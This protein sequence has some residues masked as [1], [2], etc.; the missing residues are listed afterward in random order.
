MYMN[1]MIPSGKIFTLVL[2]SFVLFSCS[3]HTD[4][5]VRIADDF[6]EAYTA[7]DYDAAAVY[8]NNCVREAVQES[9]AMLDALEDHIR[10]SFMELSSAMSVRK[11]SVFEHTKDSVT[12]D[13]DVLIPG[14]IEPL[15]NAVTVTY[16]PSSENWA[17]VDVR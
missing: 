7:A 1:K 12:V 5:G 14:E 2:C 4:E 8:C 6:I 13:Y 15:H 11:T 3:G 9:A 16:N 10:E 17:V